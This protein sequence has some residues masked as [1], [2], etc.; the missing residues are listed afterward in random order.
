MVDNRLTARVVGEEFVGSGINLFLETTA[1]SEI[2]V[3][4]PQKE[5][6]RVSISPGDDLNVGWP[7]HDGHL[8]PT[9]EEGHA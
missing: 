4:V 7:L 2:I 5:M 1:G 3:Q 8:I 6:D 9:Q